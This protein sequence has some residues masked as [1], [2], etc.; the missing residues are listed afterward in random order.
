LAADLALEDYVGGDRRTVRS[1][2]RTPFEAAVSASAEEVT[3]SCRAPEG[4][5]A[6]GLSKLL[7]FDARGGLRVTYRWDAAAFPPGTVFAPEVSVSQVVALAYT[8]AT[9]VWSFPV[10]TVAKSERGLEETVQ[11]YSLTPRWP[12]DVGGAQVD[13]APT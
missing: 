8:P 12:V 9:D 7:R 10:T 13:F 3:V 2:A 5:E 1:W 6:G 4:V 11:G